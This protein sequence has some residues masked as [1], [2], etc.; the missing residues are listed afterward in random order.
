MAF[1]APGGK[2]ALSFSICA[3][4]GS[5]SF[6][7]AFFE[8]VYGYEFNATGPPWVQEWMKWPKS[9]RPAGSFLLYAGHIENSV[10]STWKHYHIYRDPIDRYISAF[11]SKFRCCDPQL[12]SSA[13]GLNRSRCMK[14]NTNAKITYGIIKSLFEHSGTPVPASFEKKS[15]RCLYF[16]EFVDLITRVTNPKELN[17]HVRPQ[18]PIQTEKHPTHT[19]VGNI[20]ELSLELNPFFSELGLKPIEIKKRHETNR[21]NWRPSPLE[22]QRLCEFAAAEYAGFQLRLNPICVGIPPSNLDR[23]PKLSS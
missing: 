15:E 16:D 20:S 14:D 5:T 8:S 17:I 7:A 21:Y 19:W 6:Y 23:R 11:F 10:I 12:D 18:W 3:K 4:C 1:I 9:G 22:I 13:L 2:I